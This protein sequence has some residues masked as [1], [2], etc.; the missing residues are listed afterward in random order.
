MWIILIKWFIKLE[1]RILIDCCIVFEG[2][3]DDEIIN[4][5]EFIVNIIVVIVIIFIDWIWMWSNCV[6]EGLEIWW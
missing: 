3:I 4:W 2:L 1:K 5:L 6:N